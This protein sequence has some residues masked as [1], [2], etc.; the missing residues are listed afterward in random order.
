MSWH[1]LQEQEVA[2]WEGSSLD[3][4][5]AVLLSLMP[6]AERCF[7]PAKKMATLRS[8]QSGMMSEHLTAGLGVG[9]LMSLQEDFPA[10]IS[11]LQVKGQASQAPNH[12]SGLRWLASLEKLG[13]GMFLWRTP[14]PSLF[15]EL[16]ECSVIWP[17]WGMMLNGVVYQQ[18]N[19]AHLIKEIGGGA[20]LP[21]PTAS[22]YGTQKSP[23]ANQTPRPS[24]QTMAS[25]HKWPTPTVHGNHNRKG[26]SKTSGD[27]LATAVAKYPTPCARD[28]KDGNYPAEQ[29]RNTPPLATHAGGPLNPQWVEW[30]M[31]WPIGWTDLKPL[32]MDKFRKWLHQPSTF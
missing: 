4:A 29:K 27:G 7:L 26:L 18:K 25:G 5:P 14:Q 12:P 17:K 20:W 13:Q 21:T 15:Q 1:F 11:V 23:G 19:V 32:V 8:F 9:Q 30:L 28:W 6:I 16:T 31:G 22:T 24:L 3:G 10:K 2:S